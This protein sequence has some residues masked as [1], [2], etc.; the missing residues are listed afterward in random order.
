MDINRVKT[1]FCSSKLDGY[2]ILTDD[3]KEKWNS[4][5]PHQRAGYYPQKEVVV[6]IDAKTLL[7]N[8][9]VDMEEQ[10][11][12]TDSNFTHIDGVGKDNLK[13]MQKILNDIVKEA[14]L[15]NYEIVDQ[16]IDPNV[17]LENDNDC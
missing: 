3:L 6:R 15:T 14:H 10:N 9:L 17:D 13:K 12:L 11:E 1:E 8:C 5:K 7:E 16:E 2:S 4:L